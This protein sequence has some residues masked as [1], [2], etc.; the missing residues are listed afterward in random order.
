MRIFKGFISKELLKNYS[1]TGERKTPDQKYEITEEDARIMSK[2]MKRLPVVFSH[3]DEIQVGDVIDTHVDGSN[4]E[5]ACSVDE[6]TPNGKLM[7]NLIDKGMFDKFSLQHNYETNEPLHIALVFDPARAGSVISSELDLFNTKQNLYKPGGISNPPATSSSSPALTDSTLR[8]DANSQNKNH[9][10][11]IV[12]ASKTQLTELREQALSQYT[13]NSQYS[14]NNNMN[15][16]NTDSVRFV[17]I[18]GMPNENQQ[19]QQQQQQQQRGAGFQA[20]APSS[21]RDKLQEILHHVAGKL[22]VEEMQALKLK[23]L[24]A[25]ASEQQ[26][27]QSSDNNGFLHTQPPSK[28]SF[29]MGQQQPSFNNNN[30]N[31]QQQQQPSDMSVEGQ[32][33]QQPQ[34]SDPAFG[35]NSSNSSSPSDLQTALSTLNSKSIPT[36][37]QR[38]TAMRH[39]ADQSATI[40]QLKTELDN[41]RKQRDEFDANGSEA[42]QGLM[43]DLL[44]QQFT[45]NDASDFNESVKSVKPSFLKTI[46]AASAAVRRMKEQTYEAEEAHVI[47]EEASSKQN[48]I[49]T[50]MGSDYNENLEQ[51]RYNSSIVSASN[52]R[53]KA[54]SGKRQYQAPVPQQYEHQHVSSG[55]AGWEEKVNKV[56]PILACSRNED[57]ARNITYADIYTQNQMEQMKSNKSVSGMTSVMTDS[58]VRGLQPF[59]AS[60][61]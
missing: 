58:S 29:P 47:D 33:Q 46:V 22:S 44:G 53:K 9:K 60:R 57:M 51:N 30:N 28:Q 35:G 42:L 11:Y 4:W 34:Q 31:Q 39:I 40:T 54:L 49:R 15:K 24:D 59:G 26:Q 17:P 3:S 25:D 16:I 10:A 1:F 41:M 12:S 43:K 21:G 61:R 13:T 5:V 52:Q 38:D 32:Q 20:A 18:N 7:C 8:D 27:Q 56:Y 55:S 23:L 14:N 48:I 6:D 37:L 2:R 50:I 45:D 19:Q 36:K